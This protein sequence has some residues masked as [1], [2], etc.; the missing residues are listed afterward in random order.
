MRLQPGMRFETGLPP[1][2]T[3][4]PIFQYHPAEAPGVD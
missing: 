2:R 1:N 3:K 4:Q